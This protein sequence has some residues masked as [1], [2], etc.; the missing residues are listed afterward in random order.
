M[1]DQAAAEADERK[2]ARRRMLDQAIDE[3]DRRKED[4][5]IDEA[6]R[7]K[8]D[9]II[10]NNFDLKYYK[11]E[12]NVITLDHV[13]WPFYDYKLDKLGNAIYWETYYRV[14]G[15]RMS[16]DQYLLRKFLWL[17]K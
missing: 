12:N 15:I 9:Q 7:R 17:E 3:A 4:Q 10:K 16:E 11:I 2:E 5:I 8:E 1:L 14:N 6:D 13:E